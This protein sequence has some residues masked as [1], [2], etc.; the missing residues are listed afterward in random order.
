MSRIDLIATNSK[1][2]PANGDVDNL[3]SDG[4]TLRRRLKDQ[5]RD[6]VLLR[7]RRDLLEAV[8]AAVVDLIHS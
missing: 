3:P 6:G 5:R 1:T 2:N 4:R 8:E 7:L